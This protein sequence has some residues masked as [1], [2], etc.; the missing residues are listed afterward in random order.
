MERSPQTDRLNKVIDEMLVLFTET[1]D[2]DNLTFS[3]RKE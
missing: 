1:L 2:N 3:L